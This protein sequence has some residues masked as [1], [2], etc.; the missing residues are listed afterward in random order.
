MP[1]YHHWHHSSQKEAIDKNFAIHFPWI[2][3]VFGTCYF[4]DEWPEFY[5][6]DGEQISK[7]FLRQTIDP[8]IRGRKSLSSG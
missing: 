8:F 2:D 4:P 7:S 3:R 5:G 6:L 1:R